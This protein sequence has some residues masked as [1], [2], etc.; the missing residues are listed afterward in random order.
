MSKDQQRSFT[1][2]LTIPDH[3]LNFLKTLHGEPVIVNDTRFSG[4][5]FAGA[6]Q[7]T[8]HSN[9][10]SLR[11]TSKN[12]KA[13]PMNLYFRNT[14]DYY[15]IYI[16]SP[17]DFRWQCISMNPQRI[18]GAYPAAGSETTSYNLL[19]QDNRIVTLDDLKGPEHLVWLRARNSGKLGGVKLRGS[20]HIYLADA[21][22]D[23]APFIL[24]ILKRNA[25]Y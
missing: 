6:I 20:P 9:L 4:G 2:T 3:Q 24:N 16:H 8:D 15:V 17:A 25:P 23:G 13:A 19:D 1:A 14:D 7:R 5:H 10:L 11:P 21:G 12:E 18:L 22:D